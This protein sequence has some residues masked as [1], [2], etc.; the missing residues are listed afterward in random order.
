MMRG[1]LVALALSSVAIS[2]ASAADTY[3]VQAGTIACRAEALLA[4][5]NP[6]APYAGETKSWL[7]Q[8]AE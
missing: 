6:G 2:A 7:P 5:G 8:A 3:F 4:H 1:P